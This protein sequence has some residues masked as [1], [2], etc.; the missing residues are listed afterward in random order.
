VTRW[1]LPTQEAPRYDWRVES[2][3]AS[4][5]QNSS[6][7]ARQVDRLLAPMILRAALHGKCREIGRMIVQ[8]M[9]S[10]NNAACGWRARSKA[11][12]VDD[13][14]HMKAGKS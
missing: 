4:P 2:E 6:R 3:E 7:R 1:P 5:L 10:G 11:G 8:P 13:E 12:R 14:R 9:R